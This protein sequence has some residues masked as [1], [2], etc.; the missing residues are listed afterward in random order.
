MSGCNRENTR[1]LSLPWAAL[2][3]SHRI[4]ITCNQSPLTARPLQLID[5]LFLC[6]SVH[7]NPVAGGNDRT[8]VLCPKV[9]LAET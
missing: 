1:E 4:R 7:S 5:G 3:V 8:R 9:D 6:A 2:H